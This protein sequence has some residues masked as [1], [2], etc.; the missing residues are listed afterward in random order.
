M[1]QLEKIIN[2]HK[3]VWA[4]R[5][6]LQIEGSA[7]KTPDTLAALR[8]ARGELS[9]MADMEMRGRRDDAR[10]NK[11]H[12]SMT[13]E[14]ADFLM[15]AFTAIGDIDFPTDR[16]SSTAPGDPLDFEH[17]DLLDI[18]CRDIAESAVG[19][20]LF[21]RIDVSF[22]HAMHIALMVCPDAVDRVAYRLAKIVEKH[23]VF[24][25]FDGQTVK[26]ILRTKRITIV[27]AGKNRGQSSEDRIAA[28]QA[29]SEK[30]ANILGEAWN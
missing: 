20:H 5:N 27:A 11:R 4:T 10:N 19:Y 14:A 2:A 29:Y 13:D 3:L 9:E 21:G 12:D 7:W 1:K 17:D 18:A 8:Y 25:R 28:Y 22:W 23:G 6:E 30:W 15:M 16:F 26:R 24:G